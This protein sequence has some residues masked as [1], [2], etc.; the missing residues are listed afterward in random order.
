MEV[1]EGEVNVEEGG[2]QTS[3]FSTFVSILI[4]VVSVMGAILAWRVAIASSNA[5][6]ADTRGLLAEVDRADVNLQASIQVF[7]HKAAY[8]SFVTNK[9]LGEAFQA[10]GDENQPLSLAFN[11]AAASTLD[12]LPRIYIDRDENFD[13]VR[14]QGE[15]EAEFSLNRDTNP[16]PQYDAADRSR[17]KALW[18]LVDLIWFS[19]ALVALTLA[20]AIRNPLRYFFLLGGL[21]ILFTGS[22]AAI[23]IERAIP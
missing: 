12:F 18:L 6:S 11:S 10:L 16:Q 9:S 1:S 17:A 5:S 13:F 2:G 4:A 7:G 23:L 22:L 20:D 15:T 8:V 21:G 14:D 19:G 3:R